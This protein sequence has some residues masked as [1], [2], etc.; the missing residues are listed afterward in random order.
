MAYPYAGVLFDLDGTLLDTEGIILESFHHAVKTVL[1]RDYPDEVLSK[2]VGQPLAVQMWDFTDDAAVYDELLRT[3]RAYN[4]AIHDSAVSAFAGVVDA[5]RALHESD[6]RL[7]VVTSKRHALAVRGLE[8]CGVAPYLAFVIGSDD[9]ETHKPD[10]GPVLHGCD[11][12][13]LEPAA[14][15]YVGDSPYDL[16]AGRGAGCDTAAA[17]WGMFPVAVLEAE[18]PDY[19]LSAI[20]ELLAVTR[21]TIAPAW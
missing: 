16:Q 9:W 5:L 15:L 21:R 12:L 10:P 2:K 4:E 13:G 14:C 19:E 11:L 17:L 7:G 20:A 1:G 3:Y 18:R 6:V 8:V